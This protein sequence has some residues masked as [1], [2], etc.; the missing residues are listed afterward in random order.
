MKKLLTVLF[1]LIFLITSCENDEINLKNEGSVQFGFSSNLL[2]KNDLKNS[3]A[4]EAEEPA[5]VVL[6][7]KDA[8]GKLVYNMERIELYN[9][10]GS[11][12]SKPLSLLVGNF[13]LEKFM[14]VN[15]SD[16]VIYV[17]PIQGSPNAYLVEYPLPLNFSVS[18]DAVTKVIPEVL[19]VGEYSPEDFGYS[20]FSFDVVETFD[21]LIGVFVYNESIQNFE[22]T[23]A[24]LKVE[25][26]GKTLFSDTLS[27][28]TNKVT[29]TDGYSSYILTV[30][31]DGYKTWVDTLTVDELKLYYSSEDNGPLEVILDKQTEKNISFITD[32]SELSPVNV[33]LIGLSTLN[34]SIDWGDGFVE[35]VVVPVGNDIS[36]YDHQYSISN[37]Y[38]VKIS[39]NVESI[40]TF[41]CMSSNLKSI[42]IKQATNIKNININ[43]NMLSS[44]D[45][46]S[47]KSLQVLDCSFN[48]ISTIDLSNNLDLR[49]LWC[50]NNHIEMIDISGLKR[51]GTLDCSS[52][53]LTS[54]NVSNNILLNYLYFS[55]NKISSI[56]VSKN[57]F[58]SELV[59]SNN[60]LTML[61]VSTNVDLNSLVFMGNNISNIDISRNP[62]LINLL[63]QNTLISNLNVDNNK[64]LQLLSVEA[65]MFDS[66][67]V[68]ELLSDILNNVKLSNVMNGVLRLGSIQPTGQGLIDKQTLI[69]VYG[70]QVI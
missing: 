63:C 13:T 29:V 69:E 53:N 61:D 21:F 52:N 15:N 66:T 24:H 22:L 55:D 33:Q 1:S 28:I 10:N 57:I 3:S 18:K 41:F 46:S 19:S 44:I 65:T 64:K 35:D 23:N 58:L 25:S 68:N 9:M 27:T 67:G 31:K 49:T 36:S 4:K 34:L 5:A 56:N 60:L 40:G 8:N 70:W 26:N 16:S 39:G 50:G 47:N 45:I 20:T 32:Q 59:C 11:Y 43:Y 17:T 48:S 42:N 38:T 51:L 6:S 37:Q 30:T 2:T 7:V 62:E 14:I 12:I 54:L